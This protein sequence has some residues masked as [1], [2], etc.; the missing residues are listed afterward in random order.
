MFQLSG[1][2]GG[3]FAALLTSIFLGSFSFVGIEVIAATAEE[4][5]FKP[6]PHPP[7]DASPQPPPPVGAPPTQVDHAPP[8]LPP[9]RS[10]TDSVLLDTTTDNPFEY[11][12]WVPVAATFIYLWGGWMVSHNIAWNDSRLPGLGSGSHQSSGSIFVTSGGMYSGVMEQAVTVLLMLNVA[13]TSSSA[14]YVA[15][16]T[17]FGFAYN[18]AKAGKQ[19]SRF[20]W[21]FEMMCRLSVKSKFDVPYR[22]VFASSW[23]F[24]LPFLK[25]SKSPDLYLNVSNTFQIQLSLLQTKF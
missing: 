17:L 4:A 10:V 2:P 18:T 3:W 19:N 15:S 6:S 23:L 11:A 8:R 24:W 13:S 12:I 9:N 22:A 7:P 1:T 14:L 5:K 25:Y 21:Y 20:A 16:R